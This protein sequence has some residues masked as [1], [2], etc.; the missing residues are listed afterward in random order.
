MRYFTVY[1]DEMLK[2]PRSWIGAK[3]RIQDEIN[4]SCI[5]DFGRNHEHQVFGV[6][7]D[8]PKRC[9]SAH[10][11]KTSLPLRVKQRR[12]VEKSGSFRW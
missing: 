10:V 11:T 1:V 2:H 8:H 4:Q 12:P 7:T 5:E 6:M 9:C 3:R